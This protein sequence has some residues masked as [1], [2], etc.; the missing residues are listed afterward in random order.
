MSGGDLS[1][2]TEPRGATL[3]ISASR[4]NGVMVGD[5]LLAIGLSAGANILVCRAHGKVPLL[6]RLR[7]IGTFVPIGSTKQTACSI[8]RDFGASGSR[9]LCK[10]KRLRGKRVVRHKVRGCLI[11]NGARSMAPI[12]RSAGKCNMF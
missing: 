12:F 9:K 2:V 11:R 7:G 4:S 6:G 8:C 1:I 3:G 5:H 10:L